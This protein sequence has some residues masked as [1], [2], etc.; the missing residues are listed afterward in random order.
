MPKVICIHIGARAHYLIPKALQEKGYL[1]TLITD[2][3]VGSPWLRWLLHRIPFAVFRSL[4]GRYNS[5]IPSFKVFSF[6]F[7]F[8]IFES[9]LR[10]KY[11]Y[12]W[13]LILLR[14]QKF[15]TEALKKIK[16]ISDPKVL[17]GI[18]YTS[19]K[20][21]EYARNNGIKTVLYQM[22]PGIEEE[23]LVA[24]LIKK[25]SVQTT[26]ERAPESYW[27]QWRR[28]CDLSDV[29]FV[30]SEWSKNA[31]IR[32]GIEKNKIRVI[33]LPYALE[34]KHTDFKRTYPASYTSERP[35]RCLFLG[36]LA[37][38]KGIHLVIETAR[39]MTDHPVE[40][41]FIGRNEMDALEFAL[42][43]IQYRGI[44]TREEVDVAYQQ[45]DV[46][47]FPTFSDGF[48]LTQLEAM[49]WKLPVIATEFCGAVVEEGKNGW[50]MENTD[51]QTLLTILKGMLADPEL[52]PQYSGQCLDRV[53]K[54]STASFASELSEI[55]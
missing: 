43:N 53:M 25:Y 28:E 31:M 46:F 24:G 55:I 1:H 16:Q 14:D 39:Q 26:W 35:L 36:T 32:Q 34:K 19:L 13:R 15:E 9:V 51:S 48:G 30:N 40:F 45:A 50:I 4:A 54:F 52:L 29:I 18:S 42:P 2:T 47:L 5:V 33:P 6:G 11:S 41:I 21:F 10:L 37:V 49:A 20:C 17:L 27:K 44:L 12:S 38:R 8:L 23:E 22:D 7:R 3:W